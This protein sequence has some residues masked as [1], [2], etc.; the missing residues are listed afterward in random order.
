MECDEEGGEAKVPR[1][2][3]ARQVGD[4]RAALIARV[5]ALWDLTL[6]EYGRG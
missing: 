2:V 4:A 6:W 3:N 5:G 1:Q